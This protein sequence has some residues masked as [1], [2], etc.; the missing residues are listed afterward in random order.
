MKEFTMGDHVR[1]TRAVSD[2]CR[3]NAEGV[4]I[5]IIQDTIEA[6]VFTLYEV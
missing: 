4:V 1:W 3:Q 5:G 2:V 6:S